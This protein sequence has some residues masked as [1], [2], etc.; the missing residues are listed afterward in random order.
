MQ[1]LGDQRVRERQHQR[2]VGAGEDREPVGAGL[3][4]Q[5]VAQ[6]A[7]QEELGSRA[8]GRAPWSRRSTCWLMPPPATMLFL[9][10]MPPKASTSVAVLDDL[11][12]R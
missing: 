5:V 3:V 12:P 6:R 8:R 10:A 1:A 7:D 9:S 4:G 11:R 2:D